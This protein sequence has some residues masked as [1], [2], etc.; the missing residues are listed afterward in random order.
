MYC[1]GVGGT[2]G[3]RPDHHGHADRDEDDQRPAT[4]KPGDTGSSS[5]RQ[6]RL[7]ALPR[8]LTQL[9]HHLAH[10]LDARGR[11]LLQRPFDEL[12]QRWWHGIGQSI[13]R[14]V[15]DRVQHIDV[16]LPFEWPTIG[17]QFVE[18]HREGEDVAARVH[19][20]S[21]GLFRRHVRD[22]ADDHALARALDVGAGR[23]DGRVL[24]LRESKIRELRIAAPRQAGCSPA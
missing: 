23:R 7:A 12:A 15:H 9:R 22:R 2:V 18:D 6:R 1:L 13:R 19:R 24:Q 3:A 14:A 4:R 11:I 8:E 16:R 20:L 17:Q 10:R 5:R 21:L